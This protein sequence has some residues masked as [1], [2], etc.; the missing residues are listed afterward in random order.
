MLA[1][2]LLPNMEQAGGFLTGLGFQGWGWLWPLLIP[3][4]AAAVGFFATRWAALRSDFTLQVGTAD[5]REPTAFVPLDRTRLKVS[6]HF[7]VER[8]STAETNLLHKSR[9]GEIV[10]TPIQ[11][12]DQGMF[13]IDRWGMTEQRFVYQTTLIDAIRAEVKLTPAP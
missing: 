11:V 7:L 10:S 2:A 3:I 13:F 4:V 8:P 1:I 9:T 5:I 6:G 12:D